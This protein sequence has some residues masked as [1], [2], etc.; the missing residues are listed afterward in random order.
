MIE[1]IP[2]TPDGCSAVWRRSR[3]GALDKHELLESFRFNDIR[4]KSASDDDNVDRASLRLG[5]T[6]RQMSERRYIRKP[7]KV[8]P[9][10]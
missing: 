2:Y 10:K 8:D 6:N 3:Q 9:S 7:R 4:A 1:K 5:H